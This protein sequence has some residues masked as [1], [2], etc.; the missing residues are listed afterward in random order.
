MPRREGARCWEFLR[1]LLPRSARVRIF[2]PAYQDLIAELAARPR[3]RFAGMRVFL[4]LIDCMRVTAPGVFVRN[5]R[6]TR[7]TWGLVA[8]LG[9]IV[10]IAK[11]WGPIAAQYAVAGN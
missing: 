11:L 7:W 10:V 2:E 4:L 1:W 5:R 3:V 6:P 8:A 9:V